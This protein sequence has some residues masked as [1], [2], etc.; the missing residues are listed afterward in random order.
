MNRPRSVILLVE[1]D[2]LIL[3]HSTMALEDAGYEVIAA[4]DGEAALGEISRQANIVALFTDVGLP[5]AVDGVQ[6]AAAVRAAHPSASIV[7]TSGQD[8]P[9]IG[10]LPEGGLFMAKP[11]TAAQLR[12]AL[13]DC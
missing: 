6:V 12:R 1:D 10:V 4:V 3:I 2:P 8:A 9:N 7:V 13:G 11:Y 5:G